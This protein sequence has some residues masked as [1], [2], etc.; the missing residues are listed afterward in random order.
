MTNLVLADR[1][2]LQ[3]KVIER[4][5]KGDNPTA[6]ARSLNI[7][8]AEVLEHIDE[9]KQVA[10]NDKDLHGKAVDVLHQSDAAISNVVKEM[11]GVVEEIDSMQ[12]PDLKTKSTTLKALADIEAKRVDTW[13]KAG[14]LDDAAMGD[15]LAAQEEKMKI[16]KDILME[17]SSHCDNCRVEVA[18]R[19][20]R[21]SGTAEPII[22][23]G[24]VS[25]QD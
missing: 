1:Y 15:Q 25:P 18:R 9:F 24:E 21:F 23:E 20:A 16:I 11:W 4:Y 7:K 17:V 3:N 2:E 13:Q 10:R 6:I 8:R 12:V 5:L 22:I 19:L 14:L